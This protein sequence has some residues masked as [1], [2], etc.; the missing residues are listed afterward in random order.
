MYWISQP[1]TPTP[2]SSDENLPRGWTSQVAPNG[3]IFFIGECWSWDRAVLVLSNLEQWYLV[4]Y[5]IQTS[6]LF[7]IWI[8][9]SILYKSLEKTQY[10]RWL[11]CKLALWF[12]TVNCHDLSVQRQIFGQLLNY[13]LK[14]SI[15]L[16]RWKSVL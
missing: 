1:Q 9:N 13:I 14:D 10:V 12:I 16:G 15:Y 7:Q 2:T 4:H 3:R 5:Y 6:C 8:N 11:S